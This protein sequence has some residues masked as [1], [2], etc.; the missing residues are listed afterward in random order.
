MIFLSQSPQCWENRHVLKVI[1]L[2]EIIVD[3]HVVVS[4]IKQDAI[5]FHPFSLIDNIS[6]SYSMI[7]H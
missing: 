5:A 4:M 3:L 2:L 1:Y 7:P 6:H